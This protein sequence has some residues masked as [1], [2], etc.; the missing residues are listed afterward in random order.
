MVFELGQLRSHL[1]SVNEFKEWMADALMEAKAALSKSKDEMAKYY[2]QRRTPAPEYQPGD[3]VYLDASDIHT[4]RPSQK[5]SHKRLGPSA[6]SGKS[7]M[8]HTNFASHLQ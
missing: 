2:D 3:K 1:E 4:T 6:L 5:L 8:G 7:E